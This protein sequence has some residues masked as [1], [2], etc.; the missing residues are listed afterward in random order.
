MVHAFSLPQLQIFFLFFLDLF[1]SLVLSFP[2]MNL[3]LL[4]FFS[5]QA[6]TVVIIIFFLQLDFLSRF[7]SLSSIH[8]NCML[9]LVFDNCFLS[10]LAILLATCLDKVFFLQDEN[11]HLEGPLGQEGGELPMLKWTNYFDTPLGSRMVIFPCSR[12]KTIFL[13]SPLGSTVAGW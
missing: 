7:S 6:A 3:Q 1:I 12:M 11:C 13:T 9:F 10:S 8:W 4:C 2:S 5:F